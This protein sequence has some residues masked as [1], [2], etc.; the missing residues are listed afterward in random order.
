MNQAPLVSPAPLIFIAILAKQKEPVLLTFLRCIEALDYPKDRI[1]VYIRTNNNTDRTTEILKEWVTAHESIYHAVEFDDRDVAKP[2]ETFG[3]HE[4]NATRFSVLGAIRQTSME[5]AVDYGCDFYFVVDCDNFIKPHVLRA[6]VAVNLPIVSP[7]L[8]HVTSTHPY[9]N[10]HAAIDHNGYFAECQLYW[11]IWN[12][13]TKGLIDI[14][15]VHC[16]YLIRADVIPRLQYQD[17]SE[18]HEYV[19]FSHSARKASVPQYF[20]NREIYG[21]ITLDDDKPELITEQM[22]FVEN[23][24]FGDPLLSVSS[25]TL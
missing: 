9:S 24:I 8:R 25:V 7:F 15:V 3:V 10:Y 5:K 6:L 11:D 20:D 2:I 16:T 21:Y 18:R 17:G 1:V 13:T 19:I 23:Q 14:P 22:Q 4:W 12:Q